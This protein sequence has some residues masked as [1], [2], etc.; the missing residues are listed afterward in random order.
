M[1]FTDRFISFPTKL[2]SSAKAERY[3]E[4][5]IET[6]RENDP[7]SVFK[8]DPRYLRSYFA[9][10]I[11]DEPEVLDCVTIEVDGA[12]ACELMVSI[13]EFERRLNEFCN[14]NDIV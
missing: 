3:K 6:S 10:S 11:A 8:F 1:L 12:G 7:D 5:G 4:L 9:T 13:D 2:Y 14:Q